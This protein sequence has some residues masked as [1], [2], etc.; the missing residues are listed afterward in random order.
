MASTLSEIYDLLA[1][2]D[3]VR[4]SFGS[5]GSQ[6]AVVAGRNRAGE[7]KVFK[8]STRSR[9][10][11]KQPIAIAAGEFMGRVSQHYLQDTG[12]PLTEQVSA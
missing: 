9:K 2:G 5:T 1:R 3:A 6:L 4:V 11:T 7:A 10:W 12:N 8:Y